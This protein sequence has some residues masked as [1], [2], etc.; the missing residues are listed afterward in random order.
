MCLV[1]YL[2]PRLSILSTDVYGNTPLH[3]CADFNR[4]NCVQ[5]L[6][7]ANAPVLI[8]NNNGY[9]PI[10]LAKGESKL[11]LDNY[12]KENQHQLKGRL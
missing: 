10:D 1:Q 9:S 6:L 4:I 5:T 12:L 2:L 11:V 7:A 3:I 8:R